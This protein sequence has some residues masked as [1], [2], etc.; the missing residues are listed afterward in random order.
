VRSF[1][2]PPGEFSHII[3]AAVDY[4][5]P[6]ELFASTIQGTRRTLEF[7]LASGASR[8]LFTSSGAVYGPQPPGMTHVSE[9]YGGAPDTMFTRSAYGEAK[10]ASEWLC[11]AFHERYGL[12][13]T[14]IR[15]F[16]FVGPYL[17]NPSA[18]IANFVGDT[19]KGGPIRVNGDG[20]PYRSYLYGADLAAWLWTV[21]LRGQ[22]CRPYNVGSDE[23]LTISEVAR[24][25]ASALEPKV[26][27]VIAGRPQPGKPAE[28][29]VPCI[30]RA[31]SELNLA[32]WIGLTEGI[33]RTAAWHKNQT[34]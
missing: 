18:A 16:A 28:R 9:A 14:I 30:D 32:P 12:A 13:T 23:A 26:E 17:V 19:L 25:V 34:Q 33:R 10:R 29:Y 27:I 22:P 11:S 3:N 7:A 4:G 21:L 20:T 6:L 5:D 31:R 15:G 2:F 24:A 8:Y 1:E